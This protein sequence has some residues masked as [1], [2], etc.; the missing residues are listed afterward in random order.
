MG[1]KHALFVVGSFQAQSIVA[2]LL[3][4]VHVLQ[5]CKCHANSKGDEYSALH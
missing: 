3:S 5:L 1:Q 4:T 2:E